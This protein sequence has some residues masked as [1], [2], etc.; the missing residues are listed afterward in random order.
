M[1]FF[2]RNL[3]YSSRFINKKYF[4]LLHKLNESSRLN[5]IAIIDSNGQSYTYKEIN[6]ASS[7]LVQKIYQLYSNNN[8]HNHSHNNN[9][10]T[11]LPIKTI[12]SFHNPSAFY[13]ITSLAS[14]KIGATVV[15]LSISHTENE[16]EY[17]LLDSNTDLI[18]TTSTLLPKLPKLNIPY[19]LLDEDT[20]QYSI[21]SHDSYKINKESNALIVYTSGTTNKPK[22]VVHTHNSLHHMILSLTS[23][24]EYNSNDRILHF[25]PLHH[26]HGILNKLW[27]VLYSGGIVEFLKSTNPIEIWKRLSDSTQLITLFMAVPT[28][29]IK[30][31]ESYDK[32]DLPIEIFQKALENIKSIRLMVS[33]SASL[34]VPVLYRWRTLTGHT[35]LERYGMTEVGMALTNPIHG[36]R[37]EGYV[38]SPLPFVQ[39]KIIPDFSYSE[40]HKIINNNHNNH[41]NHNHNNHNKIEHEVECEEF[42]ELLLKVFFSLQILL[43]IFLYFII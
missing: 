37:K 17:F 2:Q 7:N 27:C 24:W 36:E 28:I 22:G 40:S 33:G 34:H 41:N 18:I 23:S 5:N 19:L 1:Y 32:K 39:C 10:L 25:L 9:N 38:G 3:K 35:L 31:L 14:W 11:S 4:C 20:K 6:N 12:A 16:L 30:L 26:L 13:V 29:Y 8:N 42:G 43:Q 15:P 21:N